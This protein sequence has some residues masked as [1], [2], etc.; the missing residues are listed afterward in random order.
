[1]NPLEWMHI[2]LVLTQQDALDLKKN[3]TH[4]HTPIA[5]ILGGRGP[6]LIFRDCSQFHK[7]YLMILGKN[8]FNKT[9]F[10]P[11]NKATQ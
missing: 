7:H 5:V 2:I 3:G 9:H 6:M 10:C 8:F 1:M 4:I 11:G